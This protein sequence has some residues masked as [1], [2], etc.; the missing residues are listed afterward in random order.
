LVAVS[1]EET[2]SV[3]ARALILLLRDSPGSRRRPPAC[4][5][6]SR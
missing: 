4:P 1:G 6:T 3:F 5:S 2:E